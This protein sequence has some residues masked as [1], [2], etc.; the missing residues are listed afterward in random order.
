MQLSGSC[1][2]VVKQAV[3][4]WSSGKVLQ[5]SG[6][7]KV[8]V[9]QVVVR[10]SSGNYQTVVEQKKVK[11]YNLYFFEPSAISKSMPSD[12]YDISVSNNISN[13]VE[14]TDVMQYLVWPLEVTKLCQI[15]LYT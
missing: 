9:K 2:V 11:P 5:L 1:N 13:L 14:V 12:T 8:V 10:W 7:C 3:V 15:N 4:R 6:S